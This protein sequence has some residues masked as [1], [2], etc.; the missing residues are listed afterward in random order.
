MLCV[1]SAAGAAP[2]KASSRRT[3]AAFRDRTLNM[4]CTAGLAGLPQISLP[5]AMVEGCPF[6][7]SLIA[8]PRGDEMLLQVVS[9]LT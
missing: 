9:D 3:L 6:G 4:C 8:R 2:Y 5:R 1:P 7:L